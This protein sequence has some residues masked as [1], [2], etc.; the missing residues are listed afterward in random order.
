MMQVMMVTV[1]RGG[2]RGDDAN[3]VSRAG[4][5]DIL[6]VVV[7]VVVICDVQRTEC[8]FVRGLGVLDQAILRLMRLLLQQT[9]YLEPIGAPAVTRAGLGHAHHQTLPQATRL[10]SGT[11]LFVDHADAAILALGDAAQIVVGTSEEGLCNRKR[12]RHA[13]V[14]E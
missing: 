11:I 3:D 4:V 12:N 13:L 9:V 2:R 8:L 5:T 6:G 1:R 10:A 7:I 14:S